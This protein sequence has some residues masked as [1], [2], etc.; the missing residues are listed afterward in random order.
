MR[1]SSDARRRVRAG[2]TGGAA[3]AVL[4]W[5]V[6]LG[7]GSWSPG[8][9]LT[10]LGLPL[11]LPL[12]DA[13]GRSRVLRRFGRRA[14]L[15]LF[16]VSAVYEA[17]WILG[18][19]FWVSPFLVTASAALWVELAGGAPRWFRRG[20][21]GAFTAAVF[22]LFPGGTGVWAAAVL[23]V[24]AMLISG[25]HLGAAADRRGVIE[26]RLRRRDVL[27]STLAHEV[28]TP[29]TVIQSGVGI[30]EEQRPGPLN[31][32]QMR[33]VH[34]VSDNI[35]RLTVFSDTILASLK[36]ESESFELDCRRQDVRPVLR[37]AAEVM[38]PFLQ[39]R[40]I[41]L[42]LNYPSLL[43]PGVLDAGWTQQAVMNLL[44]N[45]GK[46][47]KSGGKVVLSALENEEFLVIRVA[48]NGKGMSQSDR[49]R[50]FR[51][52]HQG[53]NVTED[54]F[55]GAGLGLAIVQRI[56]RLQGGDV[57]VGSLEDLGTSVSLTLPKTAR[58][59]SGGGI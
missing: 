43:S 21:V 19:S 40:G 28:R 37:R 24:P 17:V 23:C 20:L 25:A 8:L 34:S 55:D 32:T 53:E 58:D 31:E 41:L 36:T 56:I 13:E 48:D 12:P 9:V 30:L 2:L 6:W 45:A 4:V 26:E 51:P 27:L 10:G 11:F 14:G 50:I 52:F 47:L 7:T 57:Y 16:A 29:L 42:S 18:L 44:H 49:E 5:D 38:E 39:E 15:V 33:F 22:I 3:L 54:H 1:F 46:H 59:E 35:R